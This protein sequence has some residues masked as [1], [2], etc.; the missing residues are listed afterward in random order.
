MVDILCVC[1]CAYVRVRCCIAQD[2]LTLGA[3]RFEVT[4]VTTRPDV[5]MQTIPDAAGTV[6]PSRIHRNNV[7][8]YFVYLRHFT[9]KLVKQP[10]QSS[11]QLARADTRLKHAQQ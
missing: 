4:I 3:V 10:I 8:C 5:C 11:L 6:R 2:A 9:T 7:T 1:V